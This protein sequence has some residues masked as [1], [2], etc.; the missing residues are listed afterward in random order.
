M[1]Q[2]GVVNPTATPVD[3]S[4]RAVDVPTGGAGIAIPGAT[5][6][7]PSVISSSTAIDDTTANL[8]RLKEIDAQALTIKDGLTVQP[9]RTQQ[10]LDAESGNNNRFGYD[11]KGARVENP[12]TGDNAFSADQLT[13]AG[14]TDPL[15]EG[16]LFDAG[17]NIYY[18]PSGAS[19]SKISD[20][21]GIQGA[22]TQANDALGLEGDWAMTQMRSII[23]GSDAFLAD[24]ISNIMAD[25]Q[26]RKSELEKA[27]ASTLGSLATTGYRYGTARYAPELNKSL[28]GVEERAGIQ[29][30]SDLAAQTQ[31]LIIQAKSAAQTGKFEMLSK[32][33]GEIDKKRTEQATAAKEL[34]T[35]KAAVDKLR[36]DRLHQVSVDNSINGLLLQG[37]TDPKQ[38]LDF[39]NYDDKG[40]LIGDVTADEV[41][42]A[43][44]NLT[45]SD[46]NAT[47]IY[48]IQKAAFQSSAPKSV[49][50]AIAKSKNATEAMIAA[51]GY[52]GKA[53]GDLGDLQAINNERRAQGKAEI[54]VEEYLAEVNKKKER[55]A[56]ALNAAGLTSALTNTAM[57][58][59][60]NYEQ[61]SKAFYTTRDAYNRVVASASDPSAAGDL[62]LIFNFMK[63]LDPSSVVREAEFATAQNAGSVPER[64]WAQYNRVL[65]GERLSQPQ[66]TDFVNRSKRLFDGAKTQQSGT[67]KEY[68]DRAKKFGI[69]P[70]LVV[71]SVDATGNTT[72]GS[73]EIVGN[74]E[75]TK[76][77]V[78]A[79]GTAN[80]DK[81]ETIKA[82]L[83][84]PDDELGR[85]LTYDEVRQLLNIP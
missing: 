84:E 77:K 2:Y 40:N 79:Y 4:M 69:D 25:Y 10:Q 15:A 52:T 23:S 32:Y 26:G 24:Q 21:Q 73:D 35:K 55:Q 66:R 28:L 34:A 62:A 17:R 68:S 53:S 50:A 14:I 70:T 45:T 3:Y 9:Q 20:F 59:A 30:L 19:S 6:T 7:Q 36:N 58:L 83:T 12:N 41:K 46:P 22:V 48:E 16:L 82:M 78:I 81:R 42:K 43:I 51:A 75:A 61:Q 74:I 38:I 49:L 65:E 80:P 56:A 8:E 39:L 76:A 85:P 57:Q 29:K 71:R 31:G 47:N 60:D 63:T 67:V 27:N 5:Y 1:P 37:V 18:L 11:T 54:G 64:I 33:M 44:D 72:S 13:E